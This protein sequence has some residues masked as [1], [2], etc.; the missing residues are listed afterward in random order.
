MGK[1]KV[2]PRLASSVPRL[3]LRAAVLGIEIACIIRDQ[4]DVRADHFKFFTDSKIVL[5][6]IYNHTKRFLTYV[7]NRIQSSPLLPQTSGTSLRPNKIQ[8]IMILNPPLT[9][10]SL[11]HGFVDL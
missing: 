7:S 9:E 8:L 10:P 11:T 5:G 1:S 2:A 4:M 6:Y 3:E